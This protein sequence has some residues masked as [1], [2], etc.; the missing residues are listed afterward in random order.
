MF[1][2][3]S[4]TIKQPKL[5]PQN[6][7]G[8]LIT[9]AFQMTSGRVKRIINVDVNSFMEFA[10]ANNRYEWI[11]F[12]NVTVNLRNVDYYWEELQDGR[13]DPDKPMKVVHVEE[14][15]EEAGE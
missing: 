4:L 11:T 13:L 3:E 8:K 15:K 5:H 7:E 10:D 2:K 14:D 1:K 6:K 12:N 9:V